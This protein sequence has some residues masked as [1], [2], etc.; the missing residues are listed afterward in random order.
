[1]KQFFKTQFYFNRKERNGI[2]VLLGILIL[3]NI[4]M[5]WRKNSQPEV[6]FQDQ[7]FLDLIAQAEDSLRIYKEQD[8]VIPVLFRFNPN[9]VS[10]KNLLR[11]GASER[12]ANTI[13]NYREKGGRFYSKS[14][15]MKIYGMPDSLYREWKLFVEIKN[16][17]KPFAPEQ[18][19]EETIEIIS[20]DLNSA[21]TNQLKK[22][23][24]IGSY[25]AKSIV[26]YRDRLMGFRDLNQ[27]TEVY[28][29]DSAKL[30][31]WSDNLFVDTNNVSRY[32]INEAAV[33]VLVSH[34]YIDYSIAKAI[35]KYREQHG[36]F[37]AVSDLKKSYLI[38]ET[39]FRKIAA[40]LKT[41]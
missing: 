29:V 36:A 11:L 23:P 6:K 41:E 25:F 15:L 16:E 31:E 20:V 35:V 12:L 10:K 8:R 22:V 34:P 28:L 18:V 5:A 33:E 32:N 17:E 13:L 38:D 1:M 7:D 30:K 9:E 26:A 19:K 27:L 2:V 37:M 39:I 14:D 4:A 3:I 40:Y 24:G 21:D